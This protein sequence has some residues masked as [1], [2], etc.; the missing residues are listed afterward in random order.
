MKK[1]LKILYNN[2]IKIISFRVLYIN[3]SKKK[4]NFFIINYELYYFFINIY[5]K[6]LFDNFSLIN[7]WRK[8]HFY[9]YQCFRK[10]NFYN[11]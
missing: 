2:K 1:K 5:R 11:K 7:Y 3:I 10:Q 8:T 4:L 6:K 9:K